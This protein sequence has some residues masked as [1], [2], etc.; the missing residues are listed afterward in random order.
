MT[1]T[2]SKE[3]RSEI[4][5]AVRGKKTTLET[6]VSKALWKRGIRFRQNVKDLRGKPDIAIKKYKIVIFIDSCF[7]HGCEEHCRIPSS[8]INYWTSKIARNVRRDHETTQ[9]Y[10]ENGWNILRIWEHDIKKRFDETINTLE[11]IILKTKYTKKT[12]AK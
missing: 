10:V 4:M 12:G 8:N 6:K 3:K 9:Y 1:D 2:F 11:E 5:R 7:W